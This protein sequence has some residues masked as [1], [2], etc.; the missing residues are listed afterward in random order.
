V[1]LPLAAGAVVDEVWALPMPGA[2]SRNPAPRPVI[3]TAA[4]E[5]AAMDLRMKLLLRAMEWG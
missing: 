5:T 1:A 3:E 2:P 4:N